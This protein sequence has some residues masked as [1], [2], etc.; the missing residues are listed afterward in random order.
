MARRTL[1]WAA[2]CA[3][4]NRYKERALARAR[5]E[6]QA[7]K[8]GTDTISDSVDHLC[9]LDER[10]VRPSYFASRLRCSTTCQICS[11][12]SFGW[13]G[14]DVP[15]DPNLMI[16]NS[17]PSGMS[18][19]VLAQAKLRGGGLNCVARGPLPSPRSP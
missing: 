13:D 10:S 1:E 18:L 7:K 19:T 2:E 16:Q 9:G 3:A 8:I 12:V 5:T 17:C 15:G 14:I 11:S 4:K 6:E